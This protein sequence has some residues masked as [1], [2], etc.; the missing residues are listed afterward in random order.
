VKDGAQWGPSDAAHLA[1]AFAKTE[2]ATVR[3]CASAH[4]LALALREVQAVRLARVAI[5]RIQRQRATGLP[6]ANPQ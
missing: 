5:W 2:R 4:D 6:P 1:R 3:A